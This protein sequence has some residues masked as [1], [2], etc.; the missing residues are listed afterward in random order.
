ME[1]RVDDADTVGEAQRQSDKAL[2]QLHSKVRSN[3]MPNSAASR[4]GHQRTQHRSEVLSFAAHP[5]IT[6]QSD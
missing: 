5:S 2:R 4:P 3:R 1:P 6:T